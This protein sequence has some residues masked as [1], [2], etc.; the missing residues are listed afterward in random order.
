M[1]KGYQIMCRVQ[2]KLH[3][4]SDDIYTEATKNRAD[5]IV[6]DLTYSNDPYCDFHLREMN[7]IDK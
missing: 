2:G 6:K 1:A 7:I 5:K 3:P 4:W